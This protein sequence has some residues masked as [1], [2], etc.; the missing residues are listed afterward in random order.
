ML[1]DGQIKPVIAEKLPLLDAARGH[2]LLES[3]KVSGN[4]VLLAPELL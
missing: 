1:A 2:A 4:I 3:G